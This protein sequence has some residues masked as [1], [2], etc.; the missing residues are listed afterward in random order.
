MFGPVVICQAA[1][2]PH[3]SRAGREGRSQG[4]QDLEKRHP[5]VKG[6]WQSSSSLQLGRVVS[7][8]SETIKADC[9]LSSVLIRMGK[10]NSKP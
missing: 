5:N 4:L 7:K 9:V 3:L 10:T 8:F 6:K 1:S 2:V